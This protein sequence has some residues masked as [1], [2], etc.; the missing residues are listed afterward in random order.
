[1]SSESCGF[2]G[3]RGARPGDGYTHSIFAFMQFVHFGF[4][5]HFTLRLRHVTQERGLRLEFE[6]G[7]SEPDGFDL[8]IRFSEL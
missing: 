8:C 5:S 6:F 2:R 7:E 1:M 3:F 4:L